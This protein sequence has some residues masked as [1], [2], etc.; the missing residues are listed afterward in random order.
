LPAT[1]SPATTSDTAATLPTATP[2]LEVTST[3]TPTPLPVGFPTPELYSVVVAEQVFEN[4]RMIW[5]EPNDQI[6]VLL[7]EEGEIDPTSGVWR[8]IMDTFEEGDIERVD[9]LDPP[10]GTI[11]ESEIGGA[12]PMQPVRGFGKVW[13]DNPDIQERIG[14]A[15][16]PE[17]L[18]TTRY[19]YH[20]GGEMADGTYQ[21][22]P[23]EYHIGS[24]FQYKLI[25]YE[26]DTPKAP[27]EERSGTWEIR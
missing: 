20:A 11:T 12:S 3:I 4:G 14:W 24:L 26:E 7:G 17:Q 23:G 13:R 15:L 21:P 27:C 8:C 2:S 10:Q 19:E 22:G 6:W 9:E 5:F 18:H 1:P 16:I 25:L